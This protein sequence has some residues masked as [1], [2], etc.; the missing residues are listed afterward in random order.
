MALTQERRAALLAAKLAALV[1]TR[2]APGAPAGASGA[3]ASRL[4]GPFPGGATLV[5]ADA[6][7]APGRSQGWVLA[8]DQ[9]E[10]A[11][12]PALAWAA[13]RGLE[14]DALHVVADHHA[15][16]LARRAATF[17]EPPH[18]W[19][20]EGAELAPADAA[21]V[22]APVDA[23]AAALELVDLL[24]D[25]GVDVVVD[26]GE[27]I[28]EVR[29]LEV[30]RVVVGESGVAH[31]EVGVGR[32]DREAFAV[33]HADQDPRDA[34][35]SVVATVSAQR[36]AGTAP[37]PL[38]RLGASRW[39]R[40]QLVAD[41]ARVGAAHLRAVPGV[42]PRG[43]VKES[44]PV[45]AVGADAEGRPLVV[46]T[47]IGIDLDLVPAAAD[48]RLA[49]APGARLVLAL[50]ERDAHPV[51]RRLASALV[52]PAEVVALPGDWREEER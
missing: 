23:P 31:L 14:A 43:G 34:L 20:V 15:G 10:R 48:L 7:G 35:R 1:A 32:N 4:P 16:L 41:P 37:H 44:V 45:A 49:H 17:A 51:T 2:T 8:E 3:P 18:V 46:V 33:M 24:E 42:L 28:G 36:R 50:P 11:L 29:G 47:S 9:A 12:G 52:E 40:A 5:V 38:N 30:A 13:S 22:T 39:L 25:E 27:V 21:P 26:H 6:D 19:R